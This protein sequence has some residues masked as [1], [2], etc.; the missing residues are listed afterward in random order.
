MTACWKQFHAGKQSD[1][2]LLEEAVRLARRIREIQAIP[3]RAWKDLFVLKTREKTIMKKIS[4]WRREYARK[5]KTG[6]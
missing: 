6:N 1:R 5:G 3:E 2:L 4:Q